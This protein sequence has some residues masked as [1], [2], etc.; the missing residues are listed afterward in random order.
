VKFEDGEGRKRAYQAYRWKQ[1][2]LRVGSVAI[3]GDMADMAMLSGW[4]D[5]QSGKIQNRI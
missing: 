3:M 1:I 4:A 2:Q 5:H